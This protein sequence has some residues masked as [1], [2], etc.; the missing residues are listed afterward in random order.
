[1]NQLAQTTFVKLEKR[2]QL[3]S[4]GGLTLMEEMSTGSS[5]EIS[6]AGSVA[7]YMMIPRP[8]LVVDNRVKG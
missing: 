2:I 1:M 3:I 7:E 6:A 4:A 5:T 8:V